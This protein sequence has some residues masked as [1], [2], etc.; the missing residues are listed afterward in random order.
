MAG[1][2]SAPG[3]RRGGRKK[4][5]PNKATAAKAAEIASSGLTPLE[6]MLAVMRRD[7]P[8]DAS[9]KDIIAAQ[10]LRF[11]AAKAAAPYV[12]PRLAATELSTRDGK[13]LVVQLINYGNPD[14]SPIQPTSIPVAVLPGDGSGG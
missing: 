3:E 4:G 6:Y 13:P 8:E 1:K 5:T 11:E 7:V 9:L 14:P 12:H 10:M 2:G